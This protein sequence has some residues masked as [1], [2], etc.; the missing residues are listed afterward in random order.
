MHWKS[1]TNRVNG[2]YDE[3]GSTAADG[4]LQGQEAACQPLGLTKCKHLFSVQ[5]MAREI[6]KN[7]TSQVFEQVLYFP[8]ENPNPPPYPLR[9]AGQVVFADPS[10]SQPFSHPKLQ[11]NL[12]KLWSWC[13]VMMGPLAK[14][15]LALLAISCQIRPGQ[16]PGA[17]A[18]DTWS[19]MCTFSMIAGRPPHPTHTL[20]LAPPSPRTQPTTDDA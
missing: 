16:G 3:H 20:P 12:D 11:Q 14:A 18:K 2:W 7:A 4:Q 5:D 13:A 15:A 10:H 6:S 19:G 17:F 8:L 9:P 1:A